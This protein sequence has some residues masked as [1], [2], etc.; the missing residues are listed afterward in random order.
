MENL[1]N[2]FESISATTGRGDKENIL[3]QNK[4]NEQF[5]NCLKFLYN[6]YI[7]TGISKSKVKKEVSG[8]I[9]FKAV[10]SLDELMNYLKENNTGKDSDILVVKDFISKNV[11]HEDFIKKL[12]TKSLKIGI[13][14]KTINKVYGNGTI[15]EFS[16]MLAESFHK[17]KDTVNGKFYLTIKLDGNR[18]VAVKQDDKVEF[19]TRTGQQ[20]EGLTELA[21][22]LNFVMPNNYIFDGEILKESVGK[23]TT[24]ELFRATQKEVRKDGEKK[25][26]NYFVF[27]MLPL[28]EFKDGQSLK[29][30]EQRR[31][32]LELLFN[33]VKYETK[34]VRLLPLLYSGEDKE[35]IISMSNDAIKE[36]YE[37]IMVNTANGIYKNK[38]TKDLL[39]VKEMNSADLQVVALEEGFGK[40]EGT[41]G[42]VQV[43]YKDNLVKV[44]SGFKD[45]ERNYFW[46]NP[47]EIIGHVIEVQYF[48][49][50]TDEK[51]N[52]K[53]LRFPIFKC[54]RDDKTVED[55]RYE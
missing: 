1:V 55:I 33:K 43:K 22:E 17:K 4:D 54:V 45:S 46:E 12:V 41:L 20:I 16:V 30:Y 5:L 42:A 44:G 21:H 6:P 25:G 40:Y 32:S 7:V 47:K 35:K 24:E 48:E 8:D 9:K 52:K 51:T 11:G 3:K 13:T 14:S 39:K 50:S 37:G 15:P 38:R 34:L 29:N 18:C 49:E 27:D 10:D 23:E 19:F 31:N 28:K 36:G 2:I 26:L 53:S